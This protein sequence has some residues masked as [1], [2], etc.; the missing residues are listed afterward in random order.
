MDI[1]RKKIGEASQIGDEHG[2]RKV[3]EVVEDD[4]HLGQ[5]GHLGFE[6][7]EQW[8]TEPASMQ[9]GQGG[10]IRKARADGPESLKQAMGEA[11]RVIVVVND[12]QPDEVQL[13]MGR[14]PLGEEYGLSRSGRGHDQREGL[15][16]RLV[17]LLS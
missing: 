17:Q 4:D 13:G 1:G 6:S 14:S 3:V 7:F 10:E 16:E 11:D 8:R 5:V 2:I 15:D 9:R 12:L